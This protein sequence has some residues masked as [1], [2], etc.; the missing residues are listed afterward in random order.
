MYMSAIYWGD[1]KQTGSKSLSL[2]FHIE[3]RDCDIAGLGAH[4]YGLQGI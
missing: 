1:Y 2:I 4:Y 3:D